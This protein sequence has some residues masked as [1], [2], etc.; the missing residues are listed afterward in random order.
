MQNLKNLTIDELESVNG[1]AWTL[2]DYNKATSIGAYAGA[3][4]GA[5]TGAIAGGIGAIPGAAAGYAGGYV[6][7]AV[8]WVVG[9]LLG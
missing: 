9:N 4:G 2:H 1:G 5:V 8:T 6:S 7:G 3:A